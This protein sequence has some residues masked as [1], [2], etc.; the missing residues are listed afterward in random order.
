MLNE[1]RL[2]GIS[3][4]HC[5]LES[6]RKELNGSWKAV[7]RELFPF[8]GPAPVPVSPGKQ[9]RGHDNET[10]AIIQVAIIMAS[11]FVGDDAICRV[12]SGD[13]SISRAFFS[14]SS[15]LTRGLGFLGRLNETEFRRD[16][17]EK[18]LMYI[19]LYIQ[20]GNL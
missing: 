3:V 1:E 2:N 9:S 18:C 7:L 11:Y 4:F 20:L 19:I 8:N 15:S 17:G 10:F 16:V 6:T 12:T 13:F 5:Q 14:A